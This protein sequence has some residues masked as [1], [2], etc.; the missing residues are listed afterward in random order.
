[1]LKGPNIQLRLIKQSDL[2][3]LYE[4]WHNAELRGPFYPMAFVPEP[5]LHQ[6]FARDGFW[7][8]N[9]QRLLMV[10]SRDRM[11]G[12]LHC[13]KLNGGYT[14]TVAISYMLFDTSKHNKGYATEA[15]I[16][17]VDYL[18][19]NR[20]LNRIQI[21]V[22]VKNEASMRVA[23]KAGFTH[24]GVARGAFLLEGEDTDMHIYSLLRK[25][26]NMT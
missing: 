9:S 23:E 10:D 12:T 5:M 26:W 20:R 6:A 16:T 21:L 22:P 1:M 15:V 7:S 13:E 25:E 18:F 11:L 19:N 4:K 3:E 8:E 14:D 2:S 24:E 17:L